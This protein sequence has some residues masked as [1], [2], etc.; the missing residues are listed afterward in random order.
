MVYQIEHENI[1][2]DMKISNTKSRK[3]YEIAQTMKN[4]MDEHQLHVETMNIFIV[5]GFILSKP[6]GQIMKKN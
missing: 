3:E 4:Y 1:Q 2:Y 6:V 5:E